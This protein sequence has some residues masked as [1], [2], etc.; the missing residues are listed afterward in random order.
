MTSFHSSPSSAPTPRKRA[1][2]IGG[3]AAF[4]AITVFVLF[5]LFPLQFLDGWDRLKLRFQGVTPIESPAGDQGVAFIPREC[6]DEK[7][8]CACM[9]FVHGMG[10]SVLTWRKVLT[11]RDWLKSM[12]RPVKLLAW[13]LPGHG[14]TPEPSRNREGDLQLRVQAMAHRLLGATQAQGCGPNTVWVG[15]SLGGWVSTW[16]ALKRP[17]QVQALV[18]L[19]PAGVA[20]QLEIE[21]SVTSNLAEPTVASLK[22]FRSRA[23]AKAPPEYPEWI[24]RAA[25]ERVK[26]S[27]VQRIRLAQTADDNLQSQLGRL[28]VPVQVLWGKQDRVLPIDKS[29]DFKRLATA[30]HLKWTELDGCGHLPQKECPEPTTR[31]LIEALN[32]PVR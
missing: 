7:A 1:L 11:R 14:H 29:V 13:D 16:V 2:Q 28:Q 21:S 6:R 12:S 30:E 15:N 8:S 9:V 10:D 24:W 26:K 4:F 19:A 18:L 17:D 3:G 23:Y 25:V 32:T 22:E 31:A 27:A 20:S 5:R